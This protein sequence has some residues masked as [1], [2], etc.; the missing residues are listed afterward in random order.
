M[1]ALIRPTQL[2]FRFV[3]QVEKLLCQE[4]TPWHR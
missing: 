4:T 1:L 3:I 2:S